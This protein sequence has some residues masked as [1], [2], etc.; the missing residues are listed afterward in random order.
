MD[1]MECLRD[2]ING[3]SDNQI[4]LYIGYLDTDE[5]A[6]ISP[7]PGSQVIREYYDGIKEQELNFEV[8]IKT[9]DQ[10]KA[11]TSLW[12]IQSFLENLTELKSNNDSF[13]FEKLT[14][15]SKPFLTTMDE[16]SFFVY[17]LEFSATITTY[18]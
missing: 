5:S 17:A 10:Q 14:M 8:T 11:N 7:L 18:K 3:L 4:T 6:V 15:S 2:A 12:A 16:Q 1:F 9:I 13:E